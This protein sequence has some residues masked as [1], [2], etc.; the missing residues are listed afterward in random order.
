MDSRSLVK[1][2]DIV[3]SR[4]IRLVN[5][6]NGYCYCITCGAPKDIKN[7]ENGHYISRIM[8]LTRFEPMNCSPQC[9]YCNG[10]LEGAKHLHRKALVEMYGEEAVSKMENDAT[11]WGKK[12]MPKEWMLEKIKYYRAEVK[13]LEKE[14]GYAE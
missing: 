1:V 4:W 5:S 6:E 2:L 9:T 8:Q 13:R 7:I 10:A 12:L 14:K 3:F 11:I